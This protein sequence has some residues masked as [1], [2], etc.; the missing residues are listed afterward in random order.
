MW[1]NAVCNQQDSIVVGIIWINNQVCSSSITLTD[2]SIPCSPLHDIW[3]VTW[4]K[5]CKWWTEIAQV[6]WNMLTE[7]VILKKLRTFEW[8][9]HTVSV[10][11]FSCHV[12]ISRVVFVPIT[13]IEPS[14][15]KLWRWGLPVKSVS[16][17]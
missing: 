17:W 8:Q 11:F 3:Q 10:G 13:F 6:C 15:M 5:I 16:V 7:P 14:H 9:A 2:F 1:Q 12:Y 4:Y